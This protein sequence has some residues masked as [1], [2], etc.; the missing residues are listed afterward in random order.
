MRDGVSQS[1][2]RQ[3]PLWFREPEA[4]GES[5][6]ATE[7]VKDRRRSG[8][9][10]RRLE[11][12]LRVEGPA[13]RAVTLLPAQH[14]LHGAFHVRPQ[15]GHE[16]NVVRREAVMI[17]TGRDV[18]ADVGI[19]ARIFHAI[20]E[21]V[22]EPAP[23]AELRVGQPAIGRARLADVA[24]HREGHGDFDVIPRIAVPS[25]EPRNLTVRALQA[26]E[27][28]AGHR[29][30]VARENARHAA[31]GQGGTHWGLRRYSTIDLPM[32]GESTRSA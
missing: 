1:P 9:Q 27:I 5:N 8:Q 14:E 2:S 22:V 26:G 13:N 29:Q 17:E 16:V 20:A 25:L 21:V 19:E 31:E 3:L 18:G 30:L 32:S 12:A 23:V 6:G 11:A 15:R 4:L 24:R 10:R 7:R 28:R